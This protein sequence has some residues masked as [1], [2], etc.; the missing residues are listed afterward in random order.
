VREDFFEAGGHSLLAV[1]LLAK[2]EQD[3]GHRMRLSAF[4]DDPTVE[5]M[6]A[7]I[8]RSLSPQGTASTSPV[9]PIRPEGDR[10][11]LVYVYPFKSERLFPRHLVRA[12]DP[13]WPIYGIAYGELLN[14]ARKGSTVEG[15]ARDLAGELKLALPGRAYHLAGH[16]FGGM[17][18]FELASQLR[19]AGDEVLTLT[20]IDTLS[21]RGWWVRALLASRNPGAFLA[22]RNV[23]GRVPGM[24]K[25]HLPDPLVPV[26]RA[27]W[28]AARRGRRAKPPPPQA[29][30]PLPEH[31]QADEPLPDYERTWREARKASNRY[32]PS[33]YP[34]RLT[35]LYSAAS[36][37]AYGGPSL[38]WERFLAGE[39]LRLVPLPASH[40]AVMWEPLVAETAARLAEQLEIA[41]HETSPEGIE[42]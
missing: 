20:L 2:V 5:G 40:V 21:P 28:R 29:D 30:E 1:R 41:L 42:P 18:A 9:V 36:A 26:A 11:P 16:S 22:S 12:V 17:V 10:P 34:G 3:L 6:A 23:P 19:A 32:R 38:G 35:L 14:E 27:I 25:R 13:A 15:L 4:L 7:E 24:I 8:R 31:N 39:R 33:P 37:S